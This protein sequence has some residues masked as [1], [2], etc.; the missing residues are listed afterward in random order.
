MSPIELAGVKR[1]RPSSDTVPPVYRWARFGAHELA[2]ETVRL[3]CCAAFDC[4]PWHT[5][6]RWEPRLRA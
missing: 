3:A 4:P 2:L 1:W 6:V 5:R